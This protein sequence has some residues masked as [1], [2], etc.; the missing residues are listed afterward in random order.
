MRFAA[1]AAV[2]FMTSTLPASLPGQRKD[3]KET[4]FPEQLPAAH[5]IIDSADAIAELKTVGALSDHMLFS[6]VY[7]DADSFPH[8]SPLEG[9]DVQSAFVLLR[10]IW[11]QKPS[12]TWAVRVRVEGGASPRLD[13]E[14][15]VYCPP[16]PEKVSGPPQQRMRVEL[17]EG[18]HRPPPGTGRITVRLEA[19][20]DEAGNVLSARVTQSSGLSDFDEQIMRQYQMRHFQPA[21]MDGQPIRALYRTDGQSP[22]L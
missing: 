3:C 11:P 1:V 9:A 17:R 20:I 8:V 13:V 18:D 15:S 12:A 14:R 22:R 21:L 16:Q 5:E 4:R 19:L 2:L 6:L 7:T 10:S